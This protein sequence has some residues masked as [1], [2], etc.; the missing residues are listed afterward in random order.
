MESI[1]KEEGEDAKG[2]GEEKDHAPIVKHLKEENPD[3]KSEYN[4]QEQ[5]KQQQQL[6]IKAETQNENCY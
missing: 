6:A 2:R 1:K 3:V 5:Q 4:E